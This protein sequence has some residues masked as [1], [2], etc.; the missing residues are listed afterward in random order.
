MAV[1][2]AQYTCS[3]VGERT[4]SHPGVLAHVGHRQTLERIQ[5]LR[6]MMGRGAWLFETMEWKWW[7]MFAMRGQDSAH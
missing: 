2:T 6:C 4:L 3:L 7:T 1:T 5:H